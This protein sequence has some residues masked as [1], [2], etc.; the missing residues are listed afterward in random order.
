MIDAWP[1]AAWTTEEVPAIVDVLLPLGGLLVLIGAV[2]G[3]GALIVRWRRTDP[4]R[5][6]PLGVVGTTAAL[7]AVILVATYPWPRVW[8][9]AGLLAIYVMLGAYALAV[10]RFR[11]HDIEPFLGRA[12]GAALLSAA[13]AAIYA[14]VVLGV[15]T[16]LGH[17]FDDPVLPI[18]ALAV[19]ALVF[20]P[21]RRAARGLV[22]RL[23]FRVQS[24][25]TDVLSQVAAH[26][27]AAPT[28]ADVLREVTDLLARSTGAARVEAWVADDRPAPVTAVGRQHPRFVPAVVVPIVHQ[29]RRFGELRLYARARADMVADAEQLVTD[30]AHAVGGV[31]R[32]DEL[33]TRLRVQLDEL[34]ASRQRLVEAH[35]AARRS[36]ERDLHDGAQ[37]RLI[38]LRLRVGAALVRFAEL[39]PDLADELSTIAAE[40]DAGVRSLRDL[41]RG[42]APALLEEAGVGAALRAHT[43]GS[44]RR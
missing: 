43:R 26:A 9:P 36:L 28:A 22:D 30:V 25:R 2:G 42:L 24:D 1:T 40:I 33:T 32:N 19:V 16:L 15:G 31:L 39:D 17:P 35:D 23:L 34:R 38:A 13:I 44:R 20:D 27:S 18:I 10:A 6:Q 14:A 41:A 21:A 29:G 37:S 8:V 11:V 3:F 4:A 12:A 5:R 7:L